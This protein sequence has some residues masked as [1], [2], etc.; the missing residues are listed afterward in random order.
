[1]KRLLRTISTPIS[2][3]TRVSA[4]IAA[5]IRP[6]TTESA[7]TA[8]VISISVPKRRHKRRAT[9]YLA[10]LELVPDGASAEDALQL[11]AWMDRKDEDLPEHPRFSG[12]RP[13]IP[14]EDL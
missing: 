14:K 6:K 9:V 7:D 8:P 4:R 13:L 5:R 3:L 11:A 12:F 1:M 2:A 10:A